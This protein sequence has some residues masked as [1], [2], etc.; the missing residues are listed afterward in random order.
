MGTTLYLTKRIKVDK[1]KVGRKH[2]RQQS[3]YAIVLSVLRLLFLT[4]QRHKHERCRQLG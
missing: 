3:V 2:D 1:T 4:T